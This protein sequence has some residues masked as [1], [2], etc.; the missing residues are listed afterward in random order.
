MP[1]INRVYH[2]PSTNYLK[3]GI[4]FTDGNKGMEV[5]ADLKDAIETSG[6]SLVNDIE[7]SITL[8]LIDNAWKEHLRDMDELKDQTQSASFEQKDPLVIY[9]IQAY[10]LFELFMDRINKEV[11]SFLFKGAIPLNESQDVQAA[12]EIEIDNEHLKTN[13]D[14]QKEM[15]E[16][17][18]KAAANANN[19]QILEKPKTYKRET[20]KVKRNDPC[21][22]G[23]GKK[24][25]QCHGKK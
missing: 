8:G 13:I 6:K 3:I 24:Y 7:K 14:Q 20:A 1:I 25:K 23:S 19:T 16:M 17:Q 12:Q 22:C 10:K 18:R 5:G 11:T 15:E 9:K 21:P 2:D 4:P